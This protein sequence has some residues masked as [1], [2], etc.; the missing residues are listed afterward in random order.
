MNTDKVK[1][2]VNAAE[3]G[4]FSAA[5]RKQG[6]AQ[7]WISNAISDLEIDLAVE[8]FSR[9]GYK[10]KLTI[11]GENLLGYAKSLLAA[12]SNF[13]R[14]AEHLSQGIE[15]KVVVAIDDWLIDN[16]MRQVL[17]RFQQ[18]F[19]QVE[20]VVH[21][22]PTQ[23][24]VSMVEADEIDVGLIVGRHFFDSTIRYQTIDHLKTCLICAQGNP[25][26]SKVVVPSDLVGTTQITR[27]SVFN[28]DNRFLD[29]EEVNKIRIDDIETSIELVSR[30]VGWAIVPLELAKKNSD[31]VV[32]TQ[33]SLGE[34]G[35][36]FRVDIITSEI[37]ANGIATD[38]LKKT[39][40]TEYA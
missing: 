35:H 29:L 21:K 38:W 12:E 31:K 8:L 4:S 15:D 40:I 22:R 23:D 34:K 14:H 33:T 17:I 11:E 1:A 10:P 39:L 5:A 24:V 7:S 19:P 20:L 16:K 27:S 36:L 26:Q 32:I 30:D 3:L 18:Q 25:L 28:L 13:L 6:K 2:F 9:D 37:R